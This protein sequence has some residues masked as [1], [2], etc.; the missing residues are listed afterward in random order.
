[1]PQLFHSN[2]ECPYLLKWRLVG[3]KAGLN[4]SERKTS[5]AP[6]RISTVNCQVCSIVTITDYAI[7]VPTQPHNYIYV[8]ITELSKTMPGSGG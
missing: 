4:I 5:H 2:R 7:L 1:M 8:S 6:A 3:P